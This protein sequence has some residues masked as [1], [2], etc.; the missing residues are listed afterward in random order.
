MDKP[1][2]RKTT[3]RSQ[4]TASRGTSPRRRTPAKP[5]DVTPAKTATSVTK[6]TPETVAAAPVSAPETPHTPASAP[7]E[8]AALTPVEPAPKPRPTPPRSVAK[9]AESSEPTAQPATKAASKP[10]APKTAAPKPAASKP[11][12]KPALAAAATVAPVERSVRMSWDLEPYAATALV[13]TMLDIG[14]ELQ[15]FTAERVREDVATQHRM[16]HCK[17]PGE[18]IHIQSAFFQKASEDYRAHWGRLAELGNKLS[19]FPT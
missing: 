10:A 7:V 6:E 4:S 15:S 17:T 1:T 9:P 8:A 5:A 18:L 12:S 19:I 11:A 13:D 14:A 16:L 3:S 2:P